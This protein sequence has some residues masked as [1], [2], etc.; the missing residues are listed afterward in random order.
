[1]TSKTNKKTVWSLSRCWSIVSQLFLVLTLGI[2]MAYAQFDSGAVLG[3]IKDPSGATIS[4]ATVELLDVAK[5]VKIVRQTDA[6]GGYEFDS[7]Q[8]GEYTI[9]VTAPGFQGSKTDV[10]RVNVGARQRVD[11]S[12]SLGTASD[13]VT[14]SGAAAQLEA[15]TSDRGQT[16]RAA[17]LW[18]CR[19]M[20]VPMRTWP[21]LFPA[22]VDR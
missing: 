19:S 7:V 8:P 9:S 5:G 20:A 18:H 14:V 4:T 3:N 1:M 10:F 22:C 6:S 11:L 16:T 12:L 15:D 2:N 17:R 13:T 21:N